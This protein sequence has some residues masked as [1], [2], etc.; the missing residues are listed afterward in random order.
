MTEGLGG[1]DECAGVGTQCGGS[2]EGGFWS[3][4]LRAASPSAVCTTDHLASY[5]KA[6]FDSLGRGGAPR[7]CVLDKLPPN[8][9][10]VC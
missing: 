6:D 3:L 9:G 2:S 5:Q 8:L 4:T 7:L 1:V 10:S